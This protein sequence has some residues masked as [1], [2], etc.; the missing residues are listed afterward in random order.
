MSTGQAAKRTARSGKSGMSLAANLQFRGDR[1]SAPG[2]RQSCQRLAMAFMINYGI[3][4][5]IL[6]MNEHF[7]RTNRS[8][9]A[10]KV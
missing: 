7:I 4:F 8:R 2:Q 10:Q 1:G 3:I 5:P 6:I 9:S